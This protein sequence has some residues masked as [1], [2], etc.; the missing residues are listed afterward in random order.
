MERNIE[1]IKS[2][3]GNTPLIKFKYAFRGEIKYAYFKAEW[4]NLSGSIKD[5]VAVEIIANAY[6]KGALKK[7]QTIVE[8]TSGNMGLS[9]CAVGAFLG[10]KVA[11]F[12]PEFMSK[13]RQDLIKLYGAE[14]ILGKTFIECFEKAEKYAKENNAFMPKQ[15]ENSD[16]VQAHMETTAKEILSQIDSEI[17]A[18]VAGVGTGGT[19]IGLSKYLKDKNPNVKA[20]AVEPKQSS[21]LTFGRSQGKHKIQGL[22][23]EIIPAI[24]DKK[25]IDGIIQVNDY[26]AIAMAQKLSM[27]M[28]LPVGISSGANFL[29]CVLSG[30][31]NAVS[32]FADDNKKY[33]SSDLAVPVNSE[34]VNEIELIS[35][36]AIRYF[37][38]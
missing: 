28:G 31:N 23:D 33:L 27:Q 20:F 34:L 38:K 9:F 11:I 29:G 25:Q 35:Y 8:T 24:F 30:F 22:S 19:I 12:M 2:M 3:I 4:F 5:R 15:F 18:C 10:H 17:E 32:V 1:D 6:K 37:S 36:K 16:N 26:D 14:L 21:L 7:G 13:E